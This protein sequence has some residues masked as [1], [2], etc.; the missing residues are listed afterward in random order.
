MVE[1]TAEVIGACGSGGNVIETNAFVNPSPEI[2]TSKEHDV[3]KYLFDKSNGLRDHGWDAKN[4]PWLLQKCVEGDMF[5]TALQIVKDHEELASDWEVLRILAKK[6]VAFVEK[7]SNILWKAVNWVFAFV[8]PK[9]GQPQKDTEAL[10]LLRIIWKDIVKKLKKAIDDMIR[11]PAD[12]IKKDDRLP[13]GKEEQQVHLLKLIADH[14]IK[15]PTELQK[16][17]KGPS[18]N[19]STPSKNTYSSRTLFIAAEMG[20]TKFIVELIRQHPDLI[21][22]IHTPLQ[23]SEVESMIPPSYRE[24]KNKDG[25]TPHELFTKEHRELVAKGEEWMKGT[26]SQC[27]VVAALIAT[28]VFAAAFTVPG[29]Y[30][31]T[32]GIPIFKSEATFMEMED[33]Y[34]AIGGG[35]RDYPSTPS[36]F[37]DLY[38]SLDQTISSMQLELTLAYVIQTYISHLTSQQPPE[39]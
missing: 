15:I 32:N 9:E 23:A 29:G 4:R 35:V 33:Y 24:R 17:N 30:N 26:A 37:I 14:V 20:N 6:P 28:I 19:I 36:L 25:L 13:Y 2:G 7:S 18:A 34:P 39:T 22:K 16:I 11:G 10:Q 12:V 31:Q 5:D 21:W 8:C 3:V 38:N 27:M 1:S